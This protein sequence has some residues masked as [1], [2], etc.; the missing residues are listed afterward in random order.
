MGADLASTFSM[1]FLPV[2]KLLLTCAFGAWLGSKSMQILTAES[3]K[4]MNMVF[5]QL[6]AGT[7]DF[8]AIIQVGFLPPSH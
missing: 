5:V 8:I 6:M 4:H 1:A 2:A 3:R 7:N